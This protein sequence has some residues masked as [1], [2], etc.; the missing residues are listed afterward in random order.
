LG[1]F[2][3]TFVGIIVATISQI[4]ILLLAGVATLDVLL[5]TLVPFYLFVGIVEGVLNIFI[6]LSLFKLKPEVGK[7]PQI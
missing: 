4:V 2:S 3:G 1:I 7:V 5:S 6:I